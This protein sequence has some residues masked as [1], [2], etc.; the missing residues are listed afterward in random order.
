MLLRVVLAVALMAWQVTAA[1]TCE[2][3]I[4][5]PSPRTFSLTVKLPDGSGLSG[6]TL[7]DILGCD[8]KG[9]VSTAAHRAEQ[10]VATGSSGDSPGTSCH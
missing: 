5:S 3:L 8:R 10:G 7:Y 2:N 4:D 6:S 1:D 9:K